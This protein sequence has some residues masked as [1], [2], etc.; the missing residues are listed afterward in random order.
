MALPSAVMRFAGMTLPGKGWPVSGSRIAVESMLKSPPRCWLFGRVRN[1]GLVERRILRHSSAP[2]KNSL[3]FMIGPP[4]VPPKLSYFSSGFATPRA[5]ANGSLAS[6]CWRRRYWYAL[7]LILFEPP[8]VTT[9]MAAPELRPYSAEKFDVLM[10][11]SWI[12]SMLTLLIWLLLLP[13]SMLNPPSTVSRFALVR[14]PLMEVL[15]PR[16][17]MRSRALS[18][19]TGTPGMSV[20]SCM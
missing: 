8:R 15:M 20:V 9:L 16:P 7:P 12:A 11:T 18:L 3:S 17:V 6:S 13:E 4:M 14:L 10:L 2:K 5:L 1:V 19:S